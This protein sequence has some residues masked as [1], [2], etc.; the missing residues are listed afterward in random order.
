M[1]IDYSQFN[2][3]N[4]ADTC[5]VWNV[6]SSYRLIGAAQIAGCSFCCTPV[7]G[8]EC[9]HKQRNGVDPEHAELRERLKRQIAAG[10]VKLCG[11]DL[12]DL[13]DVMLLEQRK[14]LSVGELASIAFAKKSNQAFLTDDQGAR[15]LASSVMG[16]DVQTTPHLFGWLFF[17]DRL[18]D[19]DKTT[20]IAEHEALK[21]PLKPH[22]ERAYQEALRCR[23][24]ASSPQVPQ[25]QSESQEVC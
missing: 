7:V 4:V 25:T 10:K 1:A 17:T 15:K 23:L 12:A 9:F 16:R 20:I 18:C 19:G 21:R 6:L 3:M 22:F 24:M 14:R 13:Q 5:A 2:R 11:L 8:Y